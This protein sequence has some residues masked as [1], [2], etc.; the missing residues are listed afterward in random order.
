[1]TNN[2]G[3][4]KGLEKMTPANIINRPG[5]DSISYRIGTH[6]TFLATMLS[7]LSSEEYPELRSL[8]TRQPYDPG[9]ALMDAWAMIADVL[10][11][12]Q[13]R[14]ANEGYLRTA[15]ER[16]SLVELARLVG[17]K[18]RPGLSASAY[19]AFLLE[20]GYKLE[21]PAGTKVQT[22][23]APGEL[24]Q[25]FETSERLEARS[26]WNILNPR[27][28]EPQYITIN[29]IKADIHEIYVEGRVDLKE[30]YPLVF[31]F[32]IDDFDSSIDGVVVRRIIK[33]EYDPVT[34]RTTI[35]LNSNKIYNIS[36]F[37]LEDIKVNYIGPNSDIKSRMGLIL[38]PPFGMPPVAHKP[39]NAETL[40]AIKLETDKLA[41]PTNQSSSAAKES[42][43]SM[44]KI[45]KLKRI[46]GFKEAVAH[47]GQNAP[48]NTITSPPSEWVINQG[49]KYKIE[50]SLDI[51][52]NNLSIN[53]IDSEDP[54]IKSEN[55]AISF[56]KLEPLSE[57][58]FEYLFDWEHISENLNDMNKAIIFINYI[59]QKFGINALVPTGNSSTIAGHPTLEIK[60]DDNQVDL[61]AT[62]NT[63]A[64]SDT[65]I[66]MV[67]GIT[68]DEFRVLHDNSRNK[69]HTKISAY[70]QQYIKDTDNI[71]IFYSN[72]KLIFG[73]SDFNLLFAIKILKGLIEL[74]IKE[75]NNLVFD[76]LFS[77]ML[78]LDN[79]SGED[80]RKLK[81]TLI[82]QLNTY[83][84]KD[85]IFKLSEDAT[86]NNI[87]EISLK[88]IDDNNLLN[89][90]FING[91][92]N[93]IKSG[94]EKREI[95]KN[96]IIKTV[97]AKIDWKK[98]PEDIEIKLK[99]ILMDQ[100]SVDWIKAAITTQNKTNIKLE[101]FKPEISIKLTIES[102]SLK[103]LEDY[104]ATISENDLNLIRS[105]IIDW[106]NGSDSDILTVLNDLKFS[107]V[108]WDKIERIKESDDKKILIISSKNQEIRSLTLTIDIGKGEI[109]LAMDNQLKDFK[110]PIKDKKLFIFPDNPES[111]GEE[112]EIS[113]FLKENRMIITY[114]L[115]IPYVSYISNPYN[116][117]LRIT[118]PSPRNNIT[119]DISRNDIQK[120]DLVVI[121]RPDDY[122]P[123]YPANPQSMIKIIAQVEESSEVSNTDYGI[124]HRSTRLNLKNLWRWIEDLDPD[125]S[126]SQRVYQWVSKKD[127][128]LAVLR[129]TSI[130]VDSFELK[131][132]QK[133]IAENLLAS[134]MDLEAEVY[135]LKR[136]RL[137]AISGKE[138]S[139]SVQG[140][141][142]MLKDSVHDVPRASPFEPQEKDYEYSSWGKYKVL[143]F[144]SEPFFAGYIEDKDPQ[145]NQFYSVSKE[146][147]DSLKYLQVEKILIDTKEKTNNEF[148]ERGTYELMEGYKLV[149]DEIDEDIIKISL[150]KNHLT[151]I[152]SNIEIKLSSSSE[153]DHVYCYKKKV[154]TQKNL[155]IIGVHFI[156]VAQGIYAF[157]GVWQISETP[158]VIDDTLGESTPFTALIPVQPNSSEYL[159]Q[160]LKIY[161]NV[162]KATQGETHQEILG[163]GDGS[164]AFQ[165][166]ALRQQPLTYLPVPAP[167]GS[168][169][170][171]T[172]RVNGVRW[173]ETEFLAEQ[174]P[175]DRSYIIRTDNEDKSSVLFGD[176]KTGARTPTG[177]ENIAAEYRTGIGRSGNAKQGQISILA[178]R[179][180]GL[181][182]VINP[183]PATGGADRDGPEDIRWNTPLVATSLDHL[184]SIQDCE[185]FARTFAGIGKAS[186]CQLSDGKRRF[187]HVTIAGADDIPISEDSDL[188]QNLLEAMHRYGDQDQAI[189]I[190]IYEKLLIFIAASVKILPDYKWELVEPK[191]RS[192][193]LD[194]F[195]F[196]NRELGQDVLLSEVISIIQNVKGVEYVDIDTLDSIDGSGLS[197][198]A[199]DA[200]NKRIAS[201]SIPNHRISVDMA[202][203]HSEHNIEKDIDL[204]VFANGLDDYLSLISRNF[205]VSIYSLKRLNPNLENSST[206]TAGT[207]LIIPKTSPAQLALL[208]PEVPEILM[209]NLRS[210]VND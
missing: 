205:N 193:L 130:Y 153:A 168:E 37:K 148:I 30:N 31:D 49:K 179:P 171:L 23:P 18:P 85:A 149:F 84:I 150:V 8:S 13:E 113:T 26:E 95:D 66:L 188:Y 198:E 57:L 1:M 67:N 182:E 140:E 44:K 33:S 60:F 122:L 186:A 120:N 11:F 71:K 91:V 139:G 19:L 42:I 178:S 74:E 28:S 116:S 77:S 141:L 25:F 123:L 32:G 64:D 72:I 108:T 143:Y 4:C 112:R 159:R 52:N 187:V 87:T 5:L 43:S 104:S 92:L 111:I 128:S 68:T 6:S 62:S 204:S 2:C 76:K 103:G 9:I 80:E 135:N 61:V 158:T 190:D 75:N 136:G 207:K 63:I 132:A 110:L 164:K 69:L 29:N 129:N 117:N 114:T 119:L 81:E 200:L 181:K 16:F 196:Q 176:G 22:L 34:D 56:D 105:S 3:C 106:D 17:Y 20:D 177:I 169:A 209:L 78:D 79:I 83:W 124:A 146:Y 167:S 151:V 170:A 51:I 134:S 46:I 21:I 194:A 206:I 65:V 126:R 142:F 109:S 173:H 156:K 201:P 192:R 73:E 59:K 96:Y 54:N 144:R 47:Y 93:D 36:D 89:L 125:S 185:D 14:I 133:P 183:L 115:P 88:S 15:T 58:S 40:S 165:E 145:K 163:S 157:D 97:N 98:S 53:F 45:P 48:L 184:V 152:E 102:G 162:V 202:K 210:D 155:A 138:S 101:S 100:L 39:G 147:S 174:G 86:V 127:T 160:G 90:A 107:Y 10:T 197:D 50:I 191:I 172:V 203:P 55:S 82:D 99:E 199:L 94:P 38:P 137:M 208:S 35:T 161:G 7:R 27:L 24:P 154:G 195:S 180:L 70:A 175:A 131:L 41:I 121:S 118:S 189:K 12:Y 166:I